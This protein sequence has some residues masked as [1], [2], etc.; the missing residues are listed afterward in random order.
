MQVPGMITIYFSQ[1]IGRQI[2]DSYGKP[3]GNLVDLAIIDG[4]EYADV[5]GIVVLEKNEKYIVP[6]EEVDSFEN[7]IYLSVRKARVS[8]LE[9]T[10]KE[11]LVGKSL[12]DRQIIDVNGLK[13]LRVN[14]I[15]LAQDEEKFM[16]TAVD[17]GIYGFLRRLGFRDAMRALRPLIGMRLENVIAWK[18]IEPLEPGAGIK[19]DVSRTKLNE[20]HPAD[21]ADLM[22]TLTHKERAIVLRRIRSDQAAEAIAESIPEVQKEVLTQMQTENAAKILEELDPDE[23]AD[24]LQAMPK[25]NAE[26]IL[27]KIKEDTAE[28]VRT[29]MRYEHE[30]AGA[31][32]SKDFITIPDNITVGQA[33][34]LLNK[35]MKTLYRAYYI[36]VVNRGRLVGLTSLRRLII[37]DPKL[38]VSKMMTTKTYSAAPDTSIETVAKELSKYDLVAIPV[39]DPNRKLLGIV[40]TNDVFRKIFAPDDWKKEHV[41]HMHERE[42]ERKK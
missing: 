4:K 7:A 1:L 11:I 9:V 34:K 3:M 36:Y 17:V 16:V 20:V 30:S 37:T 21:L 31:I 6:L 12:L 28:E 5:W 22:E 23:S 15:V 29:I 27:E 13:V 2:K 40:R 14:D 42:K 24:I 18:Y 25:H 33:I 10:P 26:D 8:R 32:M 39:I 38:R 41:M 35:K 19:I